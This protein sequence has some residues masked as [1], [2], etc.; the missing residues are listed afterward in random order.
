MAAELARR[1]ATQRLRQGLVGGVGLASTI[2]LIA[3][4]PQL[5]SIVSM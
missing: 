5:Q 2:A 3:V 4:W 1:S